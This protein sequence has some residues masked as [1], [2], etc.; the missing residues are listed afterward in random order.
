[1]KDIGHFPMCENPLKFMTYLKPVLDRI[2][3]NRVS[4]KSQIN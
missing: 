4:D 3:E 2:K 1:M